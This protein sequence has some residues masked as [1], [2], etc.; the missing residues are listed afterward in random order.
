MYCFTDPNIIK[1][2]TVSFF[3]YG[4]LY[5]NTWVLLIS[6]LVVYKYNYFTQSPVTRNK[7]ESAAWY[8]LVSPVKTKK[9]T[10][11]NTHI[12]TDAAF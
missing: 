8:N 6:M 7:R 1:G 10:T 12:H 2:D 3:K 4:D 5:V 11:Q 9:N